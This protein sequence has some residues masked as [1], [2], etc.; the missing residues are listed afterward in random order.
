MMGYYCAFCE[1]FAIVVISLTFLKLSLKP[2]FQISLASCQQAFETIKILLAST[3]VL[4]VP[5]FG[6]PF[7]LVVD[8]SDSEDRAVPLQVG[9]DGIESTVSYYLRKVKF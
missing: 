9:E 1:I 5:N 3:P 2:F 7:N 4:P 8:A 6:Q